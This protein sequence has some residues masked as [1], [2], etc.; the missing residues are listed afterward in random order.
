[1]SDERTISLTCL[2]AVLLWLTSLGCLTAG[3]FA[4]DMRLLAVGLWLC[5]AATTVSIRRMFCQLSA[6]EKDLFEMG[7]DIARVQDFRARR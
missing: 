4:H 5:A 1:M 7:R 6:R 3:L 2:I